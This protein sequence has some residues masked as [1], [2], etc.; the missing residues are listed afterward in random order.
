MPR[1]LLTLLAL[2]LLGLG[3]PAPAAARPAAR[4]DVARLEQALRDYLVR[5]DGHVTVAVDDL[6]TGDRVRHRAG[7]RQRTASIVKVEILL[8]LLTQH[9]APLQP[10]RAARARRMI[11]QSSNTDAEALWQLIGG[12]NGLTAFGAAA[13]LESTEPAAASGPGYDWG[14]TMTTPGDQLRLLA[15]IAHR[16]PLLTDADRHYARRLMTHVAPDQQ[17]G[18]T[19]GPAGGAVVTV[20]DGWLQL[21][22]GD[23]QVN[24]IG[25]VRTARTDYTIAVLTTG[26]PSMTYGVA[27][28]EHVARIVWRHLG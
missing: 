24:S 17:W 5:R 28:I 15:L 6:L 13:G 4:H 14:L 9:H 7:H 21:R 23:W 27:T 19:S 1:G 10:D 12:V 16:N 20:K 11:E 26:S 8:A 3:S 2:A 22:S 18:V 25:R